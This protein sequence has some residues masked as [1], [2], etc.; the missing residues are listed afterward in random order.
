YTKVLEISQIRS[1]I[2]YQHKIKEVI[3]SDQ[4]VKRLHIA[5]PIVS[6]NSNKYMKDYQTND[7]ENLVV[8][9]NDD[10]EDNNNEFMEL[11]TEEKIDHENCVEYSDDELLLNGNLDQKFQVRMCNIHPADDPNAKWKLSYLFIDNLEP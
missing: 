2:L 9:D 10:V 5:T 8:S 6:D 4:Q 1:K 11:N 7:E 3:Q